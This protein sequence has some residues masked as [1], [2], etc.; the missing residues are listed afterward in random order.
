MGHFID[1]LGVET[2]IF[3]KQYSFLQSP[4]VKNINFFSSGQRQVLRH[5]RR[6]L[7]RLLMGIEV[8]LHQPVSY[9]HLVTLVLP[10]TDCKTSK[11]RFLFRLNALNTDFSALPGFSKIA[12]KM[13]S[14]ETYSS[15]ICSASFS[16]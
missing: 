7:F 4:A 13:C 3:P 5:P 2:L 1:L 14:T 12:R 16:D 15:C 6:K 9:T 11:N 10:R 8:K